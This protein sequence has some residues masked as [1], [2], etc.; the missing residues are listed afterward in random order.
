MI[1]IEINDALVAAALDRLAARMAD[2]SPVMAEIAE[3]MLD[4]VME[5]FASGTSPDGLP[6]A[7]KSAV[8]L[9]AYARRGLRV[10][11]RPLHGPTGELSSEENYHTEVGPDFVRLAT[12]V[13]YAAAMQ[14]GMAQGAAGRTKRG[15]PIPWG[16]IPA[17]PFLGLSE[18]TSALVVEAIERA[19]RNEIADGG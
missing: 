9:E 3:L 18:R 7:R 5:G 17:R 15:G 14:F 19:I 6:W 12:N 4:G 8:T 16:N 1:T 2:M 11:Q 10:D 13:V